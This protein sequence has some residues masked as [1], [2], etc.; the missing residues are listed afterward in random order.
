VVRIKPVR[1]SRCLLR[2]NAFSDEKVL[3]V[4]VAFYRIFFDK[5]KPRTEVSDF[6]RTCNT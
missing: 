5:S 3:L 2:L 6:A 1:I 4:V